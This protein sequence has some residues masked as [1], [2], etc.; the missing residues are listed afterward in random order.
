MQ[1]Q[2]FGKLMV[3][4]D[5]NETDPIASNPQ[6]KERIQK[7]SAGSVTEPF[8]LKVAKNNDSTADLIDGIWMIAKVDANN[9]NLSKY[10]SP[11]AA[12]ESFQKEFKYVLY[13]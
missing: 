13:N 9:T 2:S 3:P 8:I 5:G 1:S 7:L 6:V 11:G 4:G 12:F 10:N